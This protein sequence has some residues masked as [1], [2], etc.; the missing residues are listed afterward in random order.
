MF[1][2]ETQRHEGTKIIVVKNVV[3]SSYIDGDDAQ[4][5]Y[6]YDF[7]SI[8]LTAAFKEGRSSLIT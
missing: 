1:F 3:P 2:N 6:K 7:S 5:N 4:S 8:S